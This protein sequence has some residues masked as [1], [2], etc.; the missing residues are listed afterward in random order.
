MSDLNIPILERPAFFDGQRLT[1]ADLAFVQQFHQGLRWLHNRSL[2]NWGIA[3]GFAVSGSRGDKSVQV[4]AGYALDCLG[5]ELISDQT[6]TLAIPAVSG[7]SVGN[8]MTYFLTASYADDASLTPE[9]RLGVCG[10]SGAV[11]RPEAPIIRWQDPNDT[12]ASSQ[13]RRGLDIIL[14]SVQVQNCQLAK[15]ISAAERRDAIPAQQ[16]YVFAGQTDI[17]NTV[18][19]PWPDSAPVGI[20][21]TVSTVNAGFRTTPRYQANVVGERLV[22]SFQGQ[23]FVVDGYAQVAQMTASSFDLR[24]VL[25]AGAT[26]GESRTDLVTFADLLLVAGALQTRTGIPAG[27]LLMLANNSFHVGQEIDVGIF[28][29]QQV[30]VQPPDFDAALNAIANRN[31]ITVDKLLTDNNMTHATVQLFLFESLVIAGD[32]FPLNPSNVVFTDAFIASLNTAQ[33]WY[34]VWMGIEGG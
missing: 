6:L 1:A 29:L 31:N 24:V 27:F 25:P 4:Q 12:A 14:A 10:T 15:D 30:V 23:S 26:V 18:W 9:T 3:I 21:T 34:V 19:K 13:F 20:V 22:T 7:D 17:D 28:A 32:P 16:P 8:P 33:K 2:H 11:R 5:R